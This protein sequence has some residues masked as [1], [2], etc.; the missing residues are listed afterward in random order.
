MHFNYLRNKN[1][2]HDAWRKS[3]RRT[4]SILSTNSRRFYVSRLFKKLRLY[5]EHCS[6]CQLNQIKRHRFYEKLILIFM[7]FRSFH[8]LVINFIM[9]LFN[10]W[11][12]LFIVTNKY[13]R[14]VM[15][16]YDKTIYET[17]DWVNLLIN[18]LLQTD[19]KI[20][21]IIISNRNLKFLSN[22]W[23]IV[24]K[25]LRTKL[26]TNTTY[27]FQIDESFERI[28]QIVKI[29][30]RYLIITYSN[31][32]HIIFLSSLQAQ[33]NNVVNAF[34]ELLFNNVIYDFRVKKFIFV[35]KFQNISKNIFQQRLKYQR[36]TID[37]IVFVNAKIKMYYDALHQSIFFRFDDR[38]YFRL[39]QKYQLSNCSNKKMFNQRCEFFIVKRRV[40][41]LTYELKLST[42]W[43]VYSM[44]FITQLNFFFEK[45]SYNRFKFDYSNVVEMKK[46]Y[47][48]LT[49]LCDETH[50]K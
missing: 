12:A 41:R 23:K 3:T 39:H 40:D 11:N 34:I 43:R 17:I 8:T 20:S 19:W 21:K 45:N 47:K 14:R 9:T 24:F 25:R 46:K 15:L 16:I 5:F 7:S 26:L 13:F 36:E 31:V 22:F 50:I 10:E 4:S 38:V 29:A 6:K 27:Y 33:L 49:I 30:L 18:R 42:H 2:S 37:V 28:N 35:V 1:F 48:R 32:K 44:I